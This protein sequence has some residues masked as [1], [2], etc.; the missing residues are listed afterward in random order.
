MAW[1]RSSR[2]FLVHG[3]GRQLGTEQRRAG[4]DAPPR[5][6]SRR[7]AS[8]D[9]PPGGPRRKAAQLYDWL[10]ADS[11][12]TIVAR[13]LRL[14]VRLRG[15]DPGQQSLRV[16]LGPTDL[17]SERAADR[18][19][20]RRAASLG[21]RLAG[22]GAGDAFLHLRPMHGEPLARV[23]LLCPPVEPALRRHFLGLQASARQRAVQHGAGLPGQQ[24][25]RLPGM[26]RARERA[27]RLE[28]RDLHRYRRGRA[29]RQRRPRLRLHRR[30]RAD[31]PQLA[32]LRPPRPV[33][34]D[35]RGL[36]RRRQAL[37]LA[38]AQPVVLALQ[39]LQRRLVPGRAVLQRGGRQAFVLHGRN[40]R[41]RVAHRVLLPD[42][43]HRHVPPAGNGPLHERADASRSGPQR[44][45]PGCGSGLRRAGVDRRDQPPPWSRRC[46]KRN[47]PSA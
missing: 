31:G 24:L 42:D 22:Q 29:L 23:R 9:H 38:P 30:L 12:P 41:P 27:Q 13:A 44:V 17:L 18:P 5:R 7:G 4:H 43:G 10:R 39:R 8:E 45:M 14:A 36:S 15:A 28:W 6:G 20:P 21:R 11:R 3:I 19:R 46:G 1:Q 16:R 33:A 47:R 32:P 2:P 25:R 37:L 26:V 34:A 40:S 35:L